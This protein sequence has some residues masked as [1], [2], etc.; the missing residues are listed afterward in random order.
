MWKSAAF[1]PLGN[2]GSY[3]GYQAY[4]KGDDLRLNFWIP[5]LWN[6]WLDR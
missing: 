5:R 1:L 4:V 2:Y 3:D 6:V